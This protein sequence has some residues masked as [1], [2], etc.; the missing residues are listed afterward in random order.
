[1]CSTSDRPGRQSG[2]FDVRLG[3]FLFVERL[4]H[5]IDKAKMKSI[6]IITTVFK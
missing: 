5:C 2:P 1:M 4:R 3:T 6:S